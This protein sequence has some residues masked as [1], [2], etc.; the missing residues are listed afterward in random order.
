MKKHLLFTSIIFIGSLTLQAQHIETT[1]EAKQTLSTKDRLF[2]IENKG[3][4]PTEVLF[5]LQS[6]GLNTW[7]TKKGMLYEYYKTE[8]IELSGSKEKP[9]SI[10]DKHRHKNYK[11]WGQRVSYSLLGNNI[12]VTTLGKQ[13]QEG[14]YNYLIGNDPGKYA[15]YVGLYKEAVV[16][17]VY[18]GIDMC[19]Y[20]DK[21]TLRYDYIV[22]PGADPGQIHF[23]LEGSDKNFLNERGELVFSTCFGEVK[24]ADLYCYQQQNKKQVSAKF[25]ETGNS[26]SFALGAYDKNQTLI[27]DPLIYS[28]YAGGNGWD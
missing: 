3:Q 4:W 25:I 11:R 23:K 13:K 2:F 6:S 15:S 14:Y 16:Q 27:I 5:L 12:E 9:E 28:T 1:L 20:F 22:H 7:I 10:P 18:D 8:E 24:N 19:Y 26:F 21:G 17:N